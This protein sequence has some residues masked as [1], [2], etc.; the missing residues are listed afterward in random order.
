MQF[1]KPIIASR[2]NGIP[3]VVDDGI[4]GLLINPQDST[5]LADKIEL[6]THD[7][8]LRKRMGESGREKFIASYSITKFQNNMDII[9]SKI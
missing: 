4:N 8:N 9:F 7:N 6:L 2:W 5:D 3:F 1:K